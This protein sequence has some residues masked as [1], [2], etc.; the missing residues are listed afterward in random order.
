MR[1][2]GFRTVST[3]DRAIWEVDFRSPVPM[4]NVSPSTPFARRT[5][6]SASAWSCTW[7]HSRRFR[8]LPYTGRGWPTKAPIVK[9]GVALSRR[10]YGP[11]V[12]HIP[13]ADLDLAGIEK[14]A[15]VFE[16]PRV[17]ELVEHEDVVALPHREAREVRADEAGP[18][19]HEDPHL[20]SVREAA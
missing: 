8:P 14:V 4:L 13:W 6:R 18:S 9:R 20:P 11:G 15:D 7:I 19:R 10:W 12:A 1:P 3:T 2:R 5:A 17:R 16:V